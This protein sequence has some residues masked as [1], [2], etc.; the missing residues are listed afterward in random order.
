MPSRKRLRRIHPPD[1]R[2]NPAFCLP[3]GDS[4][5]PAA[6]L[7]RRWACLACAQATVGLYVVLLAVDRLPLHC[8][9]AGLVANFMYHR[10]LRSFPFMSLTSPDFL[11]SCAALLANHFLWMRYFYETYHSLEYILSFFLMTVW[12]VPFGFFISLAA[13]E[14]VLPHGAGGQGFGDLGASRGAGAS[15]GRG[16]KGT[17]GSLLGMFSFLKGKRDQVL[18]Q[19]LNTVQGAGLDTA[20]YGVGKHRTA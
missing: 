3:T 10:L 8:I 14:S 1:I 4:H 16:G 15:G 17:R 19:V 5:P 18:P 7:N 12:L 13:N 2:P 11:G 20:A 9:A 6:L